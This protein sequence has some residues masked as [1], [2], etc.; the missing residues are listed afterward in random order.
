[1]TQKYE[2]VEQ[3]NNETK[4]LY[5]DPITEFILI[6]CIVQIV[7]GN[8]STSLNEFISISLLSFIDKME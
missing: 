2:K 3:K 4:I 8:Y 5:Y 1:M 7:I 6:I